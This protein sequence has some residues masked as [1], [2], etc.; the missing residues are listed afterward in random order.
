MLFA[1]PDATYTMGLLGGFAAITWV[2]VKRNWPSC[3]TLTIS[4]WMFLIWMLMMLSASE[5]YF[6]LLSYGRRFS[7]IINRDPPRPE[8]ALHANAK[9]RKDVYS[10]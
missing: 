10:R 4:E 8:D 9:P 3:M 5:K 1:F 6:S 2:V 7:G